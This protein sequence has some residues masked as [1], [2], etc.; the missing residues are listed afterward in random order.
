MQ[1]TITSNSLINHPNL[2]WGERGEKKKRIDTLIFPSTTLLLPVK[3]PSPQRGWKS[4]PQ[5]QKH[6]RKPSL[7]LLTLAHY[8]ARQCMH[9]V[10][11]ETS[12]HTYQLVASIINAL[13]TRDDSSYVPGKSRKDSIFLFEMTF[14]YIVAEWRAKK[15]SSA[16]KSVGPLTICQK[17]NVRHIYF[18]RLPTN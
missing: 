4:P 10:T 18:P 14:D 5:E 1:T 8:P 2:Q 6:L 17:I 13:W 11:W 9:P 3:A 15:K 12:W 7:T 16:T